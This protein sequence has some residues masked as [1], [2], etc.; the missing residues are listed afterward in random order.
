MKTNS[1]AIIEYEESIDICEESSCCEHCAKASDFTELD[2]KPGGDGDRSETDE[3]SALGKGVLVAGGV[4]FGVGMA[5]EIVSPSFF[6]GWL[7]LGVF[8]ASYVMTGG[9]VLLS[10]LRNIFRGQVFDENFLMAIASIGALC[11]GEYPEGVAVMLFYRIGEAFEERAV[12]KSKRA[13]TALMDVRPDF[14]NLVTA[15][16]IRTVAPESVPVGGKIQV[17]PGERVPLDGIVVDGLSSLDTSALTGESFPRDASPGDEVLS[18]SVNLNG[19]LTIEVS[20]PFGESTVMRILELVQNAGARKAPAENF[21][22]K[23]ARYYTPVVVIGAVCLALLPPL[24][25]AASSGGQT[26]TAAFTAEFANW[27]SRALV[28]LV[29]SCPCALVISIPLSYFGGIG[30]ASKN[31]ILVKGGNYLEVLARADTAVFDKTGTLTKGRIRVTKVVPANGFEPEEVLAA[32]AKAE[33]ASTHPIAQA[34][35]NEA[36]NRAAAENGVLNITFGLQISEIAGKGIRAESGC[37]DSAETILAGSAGLLLDA[38]IEVPE[39]QRY[40]EGSIGD[41]NDAEAA[42]GTVCYIAVNGRYAGAIMLADELKADSVNAVAALRKAGVKRV[43]MLSGDSDAACSGIANSLGIDGYR[44]ELLPDQKV[45]ALEELAE[46]GETKGILFVGDGI[47]DAPVLARADCGIAMGGLGSDAA[48]EAADAVLMT[49]EPSKLATAV[50]IAKKTHGIV[51]QN[52]IFALGVK[53]VLLV[54]GALGMASMWAAVF[55]DVG[56]AFIAILNALRA[57]RV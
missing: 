28:F 20:R 15:D 56:V 9:E 29:V 23:F 2:L 40:E 37:G 48:I 38:G 55:G 1:R 6:S 52:I 44:A 4:I 31:G 27:L 54:F 22:T 43:Y 12:G 41:A 32:A 5:L 42:V 50:T 17:K 16:G 39:P 30:G 14:A 11:I 35:M 7:R 49:D 46:T 13:I 36:K 19:L 24:I 10:A 3:G 47:N 57:L 8:L 34:I 45:A 21:I 18:G 26:F 25:V 53:A 51:F 33:Q